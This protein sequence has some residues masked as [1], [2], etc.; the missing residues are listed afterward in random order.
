[1]ARLWATRDPPMLA[2]R[3][4]IASRFA[5]Q[6]RELGPANFLYSDGTTLFARDHRRIQADGRIAL[7]GLWQ[8][9]RSCDVLS[10]ACR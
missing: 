1:M 2:Q 6:M 7:P 10:A 4:E 5:A 8:L 3:V 9:H